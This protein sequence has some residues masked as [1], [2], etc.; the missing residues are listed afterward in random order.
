MIIIALGFFSLFFAGLMLLLLGSI[1]FLFPLCSVL[2]NGTRQEKE[3]QAKNQLY[4]NL[5]DNVLGISDWVFAQ[6]GEAYVSF[7]EENER[8]LK[9][10]QEESQ[11]FH[12]KR[13]FLLQVTFGLLTVILFIWTSIV[14]KGNH[15]GK[16]NFIA[17]FILSVFPLI[18][19]FAPLSVALEE[20]NVYDDSLKRLNNLPKKEEPKKQV[21]PLS[22]P[23]TLEVK[24]LSFRYGDGSKDVLQHLNL[25]FSSGEK[26]AI[27]GKSGSGKTTLAHLLRG[28]LTPTT[29]SVTLNGYKTVDFSDDISNYIGVLQQTPYLFHTTLFN[30][31]I[32]G[33]PTTT[34]KEAW[35]VLERVGLKEMVEALPEGLMTMVD[36]AGTRF[37]GGERHR[38]ALARILLKNP[39]IILLDEPTVGLDPLTE[40]NLLD[41]FFRELQDKTIIWI[42]HHLQG[43]EAV[44][45]VLFI[46]EGHLQMQGTPQELEKTNEHYRYLKRI[47]RGEI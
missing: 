32:L 1:V 11:H 47:D 21:P 43:I 31:L 16:A 26:V 46:E 39:P 34:T 28:D 25:T 15:G 6:R 8:K 9:E 37:S 13:D 17:A 22:V 2:I 5:T 36:E 40:S 42:T 44:D 10:I 23:L 38:L 45:E 33:S 35:D 24:D 30:N 7:H 27:L 14:F 12:Q 41:I 4:Q 18:D 19:A 20:T 3:K 29:G